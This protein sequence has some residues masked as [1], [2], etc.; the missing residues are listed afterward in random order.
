MGAVPR[1]HS[2]QRAD[3][4][5][6]AKVGYCL[7]CTVA[8]HVAL[9]PT[10]ALGK[11]NLL[12]ARGSASRTTDGPWAPGRLG[13]RQ[14]AHTHGSL[15]KGWDLGSAIDVYAHSGTSHPRESVSESTAC[16]RPRSLTISPTLP[17]SANNGESACSCQ[18]LI[19]QTVLTF[20]LTL[21]I[22]TCR[23]ELARERVATPL[24]KKPDS[25]K[26]RPSC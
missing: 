25:P 19:C 13:A 6:R 5:R 15:S 2:A 4:A 22:R 9:P 8:T 10:H 23:D 26:T 20:S 12:E 18:P 17:Y 11:F 21:A 14:Y 1:A 7:C 3:L 24:R 16:A